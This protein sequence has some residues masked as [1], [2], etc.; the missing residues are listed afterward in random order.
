MF[1]LHSPTFNKSI[2]LNTLKMNLFGW[3]AQQYL[4]WVQSFPLLWVTSIWM[5][6][7]KGYLFWNNHRWTVDDSRL[8]SEGNEF[9][10][11]CELRA[12]T[13]EWKF[14]RRAVVKAPSDCRWCILKDTVRL[15]LVRQWQSSL[16]SQF[17]WCRVCRRGSSIFLGYR[18]STPHFTITLGCSVVPV[19]VLVREG[20]RCLA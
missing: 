10:V 14:L 19:Q 4:R 17:A 7:S 5:N 13:F 15:L 3:A 1:T 8:C 12:G 11:G 6:R 20:F 2:D 16:D 9:I 18:P